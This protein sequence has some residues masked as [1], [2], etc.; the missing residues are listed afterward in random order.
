MVSIIHDHLSSQVKD[1]VAVIVTLFVLLIV[2][3]G[4]LNASRPRIKTLNLSVFKHVDA[5]KSFN[6]VAASDIHLGTIIGK[7]QLKNE[8]MINSLNA[9]LV[10]LP[11]DVF[12]EDIGPVIKDNPAKR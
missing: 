11:G 12:D 3:L 8:A 9:D 5:A 7:R 2:V 4:H 6:I 10:L 1:V